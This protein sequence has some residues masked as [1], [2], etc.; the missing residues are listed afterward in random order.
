MSGESKTVKLS[1]E[2][3]DSDLIACLA[4]VEQGHRESFEF[5]YDAT[6]RR[7]Y[8]LALRIT[9]SHEL[10]EEIMNDLYLQVWRQSVRYDPE[11]GAP[12]AWLTVLCR[13]RALDAM[14]HRRVSASR[15]SFNLEQIPEQPVEETPQDMLAA[16]EMSSALHTALAQLEPQIRQLLALAYFKG[17][18]HSEL[19]QQ[20]ELP[21]GTVKTLIRRGMSMLRETMSC[22]ESK[23][24]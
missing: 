9:G 6:V 12:L 22:Y 13:S 15:E 18:S 1:Q 10:T 16:V 5:L 20:T 8:S 2:A 4:G 3:S 21:L 23:R 19:A 7:M 24:E 14:R 11:R 17:Y